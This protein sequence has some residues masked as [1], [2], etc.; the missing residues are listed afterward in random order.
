MISRI[1]QFLSHIFLLPEESVIFQEL[2]I[3]KNPH[4]KEAL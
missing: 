3:D 1:K 4:Y 2:F